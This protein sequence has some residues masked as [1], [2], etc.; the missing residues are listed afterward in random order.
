LVPNNDNSLLKAGFRYSIENVGSSWHW[1]SS[2]AGETFTI[3]DF[4]FQ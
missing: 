1:D 2:D 4:N 3:V